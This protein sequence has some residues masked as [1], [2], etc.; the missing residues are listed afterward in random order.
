M[1]K[2][3]QLQGLRAQCKNEHL[4]THDF[5]IGQSVIYLNLVKRR[6]YPATITSLCQEPQSYKIKTDD[7]IIYRKTQSHLK[8][9]QRNTEKMN[10]MAHKQKDMIILRIVELNVK[11]NH[12]SN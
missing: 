1:T 2:T 11:L 7:G 10:I 12:Q 3:S 6:W 5:H 4:P 9:Y 8:V